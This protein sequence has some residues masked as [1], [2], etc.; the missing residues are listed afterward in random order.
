MTCLKKKEGLNFKIFNLRLKNI[1]IKFSVKMETTQ[2]SQRSAERE[3]SLLNG[4]VF[5][6]HFYLEGDDAS[7]I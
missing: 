4:K 6:N 3:G 5:S 2:W 7:S 1:Q